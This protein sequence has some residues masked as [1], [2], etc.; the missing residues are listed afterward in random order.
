MKTLFYYTNLT[1]VSFTLIIAFIYGEKALSAYLF[2]GLFQLT[3]AFLILVIKTYKRKSFKEIIVYWG[4]IL[5]YFLFAINLISSELI[6]LLIV[7]IPIAIYH[8]YM[9][10]KL[11]KS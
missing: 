2:L 10:Y 5:I 1:I 6:K 9:T 8:C 11:M 3:T 4:I 7:P